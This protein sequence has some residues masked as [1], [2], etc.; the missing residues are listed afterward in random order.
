[1]EKLCNKTLK[2][3]IIGCDSYHT[4]ALYD[5]FRK[6]DNVEII[7]I[8]KTIRGN[9]QVSKARQ[10]KFEKMIENNKILQ[11]IDFIE[12][13]TVDAYCILNV[14][15]NTHLE[16]IQSLDK[17]KPIFV[18]K[19]IFTCMNFF[20]QV[21]EYQ[22]MSHSAL[23][24]HKFWEDKE[25]FSHIELEGPISFVEGIEGY[26]WYGIHL[27]ELLHTITNESIIIKDV[28]ESK[29]NDIILGISG[30]FSFEIKA[31]KTKNIPFTVRF[32]SNIYTLDSYP[33]MYQSLANSIIKFFLTKKS[34]IN[35]S[36][37]II[38]TII[39]IN[40]RIRSNNKL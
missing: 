24:F 9:L 36:R 32:G 18:D 21:K 5:N 8:D 15:P 10:E 25:E 17:R 38:Q 1:M 3:G 29:D 14:D 16:I 33:L 40:K 13:E 11:E 35:E 31:E 27:V 20:D 22:I 28:I 30:K 12:H 37:H 26:F 19:P 23:R 34:D 4:V 39:D 2:I 7:W 6:M